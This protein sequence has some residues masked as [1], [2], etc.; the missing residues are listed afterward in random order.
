MPRLRTIPRSAWLVL[1][2]ILVVGGGIRVYQAE[3]PQPKLSQD[4]LSYTAI[5]QNIAL[6]GEYTGRTR[7]GVQVEA[8]S[9]RTGA[10]IRREGE[11]K[12]LHWPPFTPH[13]FALA[14]AIAPGE[15]PASRD[16][17]I[18]LNYAQ[19]VISTLTILA[20]FALGWVLVGAWTGVAGAAAVAFYPPL[21]WGPSNLLSEPLGA[22]FVTCAFTALT[23][24]WR[25]R[26]RS[27][28]AMSGAL[29]GAVLLTRTDLLFVPFFCAALGLVV[30]GSTVNWRLGFQSAALLVLG[31]VIV[32]APWTAYATEKSG[33]FVPVTTGGGSALFVGTFLPG[34]GS[35]FDM[36]FALQE[37]TVARHPKLAGRPYTQIQAQT[38]LDDVAAR[39]PELERDAALSKEAKKNIR[40]YALGDP[41]NFGKMM[42]F[43]GA[44]MW[45]RYARGGFD[46]TSGWW[47]ALHVSLVLLG[48]FGLLW[49]IIRRRDPAIASIGL[50]IAIATGVHMLAVAHG[51]Y[52]LPLM[53]ILLVAGCAGWTY[54]IREWR[55][56]RRG[57]PGPAL[58][59]ADA[60]A[61]LRP[62]ARPGAP[63]PA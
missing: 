11:V 21:A 60:E 10:E 55:A 39:H 49:G 14:Y 36:K 52:N 31:L 23:L 6:R 50:G 34:N 59:T 57:L 41:V 25:T 4:A 29:F 12:A 17:L 2:L 7:R 45:A 40:K 15:H 62:P 43:K 19:V 47:T 20:A 35:T 46:K 33:S 53:P 3:H 9:R 44:K 22:L 18:S 13:V 5:A 16:D 63:K 32:V 54:A 38:V 61:P 8:G 58:A 48:A 28:W 24:A 42:L 27:W 1:L 30:I 56:V 26:Q 37:Q 51:R